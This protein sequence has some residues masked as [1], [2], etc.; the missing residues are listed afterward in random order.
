MLEFMT[1]NA[2]QIAG[3]KAKSNPLIEAWINGVTVCIDLSDLVVPLILPIVLRKNR[4]V[5][6]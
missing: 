1:R 6:D 5:T 3:Q 2:T 4:S